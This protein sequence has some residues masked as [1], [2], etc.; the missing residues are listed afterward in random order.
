MINLEERQL[1]HQFIILDL[2][3]R[4]LQHDY[5]AIETLKMTV[6]YKAV[7]EALLKSLRSQHHNL[8]RQLQQRKIYIVRWHRNDMYF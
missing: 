7:I 4:A 1:L 8:K 2:A 6:V 3:I 5:E